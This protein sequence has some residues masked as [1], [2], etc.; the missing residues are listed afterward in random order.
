M[1]AWLRRH[2]PL[3]VLARDIALILLALLILQ[4]ARA[5]Q[6]DGRGAAWPVAALAASML[7]LA[8]YL[9]HEWGHLA[10]ALISR[11]SVILPAGVTGAFLFRWDT[12]RNSRRQ[13]FWMASGGFVA[14]LLTV[15][16]YAL[17]LQPVFWAD[18][19]ALILTALGVLATLVIEVPEFLRVARGGPIPDGAAFVSDAETR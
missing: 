13:F 11:A 19:V 16:A 6:L 17:W 9:L 4:W 7:A 10:G 5:L 18:R 2:L 14:S 3:K 1:I 15:I 12:A 8:G